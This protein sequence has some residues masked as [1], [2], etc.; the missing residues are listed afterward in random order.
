LDGQSFLHVL[1]GDG[2]GGFQDGGA[3]TAAGSGVVSASIFGDLNG[4]GHADLKVTLP[5]MTEFLLSNGNGTYQVVPSDDYPYQIQ[6]TGDF[7]GDG[8]L[9]EIG[10]QFRQGGVVPLTILLG[11]GDGTF[12]VGGT[13]TQYTNY[14]YSI[15]DFNGDGRSDLVGYSPAGTLLY[16]NEP[17]VYAVGADAGGAPEVN[18]FDGP[19]G[20]LKFAFSAYDPHFLGGVRV[21]VGDVTGDGIPDIVTAP[22]PGGGPDIRVFDGVTGQMVGEFLAYSPFFTGGVYVAVGDVNGDGKGEII[23]G[24]DQG[25]GPD[26]RVFDTTGKLLE[27]FSAYNP[28]FVGGVRV[29]AGDVNGD[30]KA[31]IIT[32]PGPGGGPNVVVFDGTN[33]S[34]QLQNLN[35]YGP[36][37]QGGVYVAAAD[38][39]SDG[40]ADIIAGPGA[41]GGPNVVAFRGNDGSML[42]NFLAYDPSFQGGVRV[43]AANFDTDSTPEMMTAPASGG[44]PNVLAYHFLNNPYLVRSL[45]SFLIDPAFA[46]GVFVGG[47]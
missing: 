40:Y 25:G 38:L 33:P 21:A 29:A 7:N 19:S 17:S 45:E 35:A 3:I 39:N 30:G 27:E 15:A 18:A 4:D 24:P 44:G 10:E 8:K 22:G 43:A 34:H 41:G 13:L 20:A 6:G 14:F 11:N 46:N 31:D 37:F 12:Q 23:T 32:G 42:Q 16:L 47:Q 1:F 36:F 28:Y 9:D 5:S 26:V 2:Q